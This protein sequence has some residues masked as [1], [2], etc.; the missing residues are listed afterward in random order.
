[1]T[2][3][4]LLG[5]EKLFI[6]PNVFM[7]S[8]C[9]DQES[10]SRWQ[11]EILGDV[12]MFRNHVSRVA[13][14]KKLWRIITFPLPYV[15]TIGGLCRVVSGS[16]NNTRRQL[17]MNAHPSFR[18]NVRRFE[19]KFRDFLI[20]KHGYLGVEF[21]LTRL[22]TFCDQP[23]SIPRCAAEQLGH[24][25]PTAPALLYSAGFKAP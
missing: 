19:I 6:E 22:L 14:L 15:P 2:K 3:Q 10:V 21:Q 24:C 5:C 18:H 25:G 7:S 16:M 11:H 8:G 1:M 12:W 20:Y 13:S 17:A 23:L 4:R 9:I